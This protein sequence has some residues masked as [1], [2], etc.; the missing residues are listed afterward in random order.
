MNI[1]LGPKTT[2]LLSARLDKHSYTDYM[3]SPRLAWIHEL[4]PEQ[5]LKLIAQRS[6]RMNTQEELDMTHAMGGENDPEKLDTLEAIYSRALTK[7]LSLQTSAFFNRNEVIAWDWNQSRSA[8][9]G[10]LKTAGLEIETKYQKDNVTWG[11]NHSYM[12]QLDWDLADNIAVSGISYSDYYIDAGDGVVITSNGNDLN[13]WSNHATKLFT[14]INLLKGKLSLHTDMSALWGFQG[15]EDGLDALEAAG[16]NAADIANIRE[17]D[18]YN[19]EVVGNLAL[20][21]HLSKAARLTLFVQN[22][23]VFGDNKRYGY[24]SGFKK[25]YPDKV[26]WIEEPTVVGISYS[27]K[28]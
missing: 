13:N 19:V 28:L 8:P 17:M 20:A 25:T 11:L 18:P 6:V 9:V 5:Y 3:F 12:K 7:H 14:N 16:G 15:R 2:T 23:A 22:I 27:L 24:S 1:T 21:Y 26:S 10:T 4:A